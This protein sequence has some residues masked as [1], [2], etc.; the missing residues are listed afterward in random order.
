MNF[1]RIFGVLISMLGCLQAAAFAESCPNGSIRS[2]TYSKQEIITTGKWEGEKEQECQ[3]QNGQKRT[4]CPTFTSKDFGRSILSKEG[5]WVSFNNDQ[6]PIDKAKGWNYDN[7]SRT[8]YDPNKNAIVKLYGTKIRTGNPAVIDK[9]IQLT[10]ATWTF[11]PCE[12][13]S[14]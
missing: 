2:R 10:Y 13:V 7:V 8:F 11:Y 14:F 6:L 5:K 12:K 9:Y 4:F 1:R 3:W